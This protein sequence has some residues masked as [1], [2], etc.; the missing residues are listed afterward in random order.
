MWHFVFLY[1]CCI[2]FTNL[3][4]GNKQRKTM[5]VLKAGLTP[6]IDPRIMLIHFTI[7]LYSCPVHSTLANWCLMFFAQQPIDTY[8][9]LL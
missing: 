8:K 7:Y 1:M 2:P 9:Q 3:F 4:Y 6:V 5:V